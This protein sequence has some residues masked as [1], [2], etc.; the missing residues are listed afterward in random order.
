[1]EYR[2]FGR[3]QLELSIFSL[4]TMRCLDSEEIFY[5]TVNRAIERGINH[6]ETARGY[7]QSERFLGSALQ[8]GLVKSRQALVITTKI[9]PTKC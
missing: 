1:M 7:G 2:R 5:Q 6:L 3:T 8:R 4:G 9:P